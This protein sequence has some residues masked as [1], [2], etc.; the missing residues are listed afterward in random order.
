MS[1]VFHLLVRPVA[2]IRGAALATG[3]QTA[4]GRGARRADRCIGRRSQM[5]RAVVLRVVG[6]NKSGMHVVR[7]LSMIDWSTRSDDGKLN[8]V[9]GSK[10]SYC[11][12]DHRRRRDGRFV[13]IVYSKNCQLLN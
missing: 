1:N 4:R 13:I 6:C 7:N 2:R 11:G 8:L 10:P 9:L 12:A 3:G 5:L